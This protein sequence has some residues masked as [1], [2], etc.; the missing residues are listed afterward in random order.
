MCQNSFEETESGVNCQ[1]RGAIFEAL[2]G[3]LRKT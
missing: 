3:Q 1:I 2:E